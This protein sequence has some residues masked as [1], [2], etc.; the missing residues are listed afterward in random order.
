M[1][2]ALALFAIASLVAACYR[3]T[4]VHGTQP[5]SSA[6]TVVEYPW[7]HSWVFGLVPPPEINVGQRCPT[8]VSRIE[9]KVSFLNGLAS[10]LV[11]AA[12]A[13]LSRQNNDSLYFG[14]AIGGIWQP[15][16]ARITCAPR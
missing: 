2:K 16:S 1:R 10:L 12:G 7:Q 3:V 13:E 9:T 11:S 8:G 4:V 14:S 6:A 5:P 15:M